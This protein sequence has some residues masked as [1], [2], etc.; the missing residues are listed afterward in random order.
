[1]SR[2]RRVVVD[3]RRAI[4]LERST[5]TTATLEFVRHHLAADGAEYASSQ[6]DPWEV[7]LEK[8]D[9]R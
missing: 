7:D 4:L 1:M 2:R 8:E 6:N 3:Q 9:S 5:V